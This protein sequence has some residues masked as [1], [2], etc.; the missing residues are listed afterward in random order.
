MDDVAHLRFLP[1]PCSGPCFF[2]ARMKV[3]K[4]ADTYLDTRGLHKGQMWVGE[5][6]LGRF[7]SIG[8]QY[9]LY[10]P[11][12][13]LHPGSTTVTFFD[14]LGNS[15]DRLTTAIAPIFGETVSTRESQ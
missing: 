4:P 15:S 7:W 8:P 14:L 3:K 12:P 9:A 6:N 5:H 10:T 1:E 11:A 13:W 2:Q